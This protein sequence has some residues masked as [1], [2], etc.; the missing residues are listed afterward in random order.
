M[1]WVEV[2]RKTR[3]NISHKVDGHMRSSTLHLQLPCFERDHVRNC[4]AF[5]RL[6][7]VPHRVDL[8]SF[9]YS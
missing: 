7:H 5:W 3:A 6:K 8:V 2:S 9:T 4:Q 1:S